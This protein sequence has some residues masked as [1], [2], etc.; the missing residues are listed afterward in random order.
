MTTTMQDIF[1]TLTAAPTVTAL[2]G[3]RIYPNRAPQGAIATPPFVVCTMISAVPEN[4][5]AGKAIARRVN[6]HVQ[7]DAYAAVYDDAQQLAAAI[8][9]VLSDMNSPDL[10]GWRESTRE[11]YDDDAELHRV[12]SDFTIWR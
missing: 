5:L 7:V 2:V 1:A 10:N 3:R 9:L 11:D 6:T 8:D 4:S 12:S